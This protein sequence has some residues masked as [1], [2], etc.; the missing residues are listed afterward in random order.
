MSYNSE[1]NIHNS[2]FPSSVGDYIESKRE[3]I[4]Q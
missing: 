2:E 4:C 1:L 3:S